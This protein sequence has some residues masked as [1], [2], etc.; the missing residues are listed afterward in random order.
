[1]WDYNYISDTYII[2]VLEK[3]GENGEAENIFE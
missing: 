1:M 3:K 2:R